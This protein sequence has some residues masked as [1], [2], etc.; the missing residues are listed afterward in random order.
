MSVESIGSFLIIEAIKKRVFGNKNICLCFFLQGKV[1]WRNLVRLLFDSNVF[2]S[3][4]LEK[5]ESK[6]SP[7]EVLFNFDMINRA[8]VF[9][10]LHLILLNSKLPEEA[11]SV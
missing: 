2:Q 7:V 4:L 3:S 10:L 5:S 8:I 11:T 1:L 9:F 6:T